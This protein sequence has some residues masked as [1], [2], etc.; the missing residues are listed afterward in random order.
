MSFKQFFVH[1]HHGSKKLS[2]R[3]RRGF[4][5]KVRPLTI[6]ELGHIAQ[7]ERMCAVQLAFCSAADAFSRKEGRSQ[8]EA[9]GSVFINKR[10]L[11]GFIAS[12][13]KK[14]YSRYDQS[15]IHDSDYFYLLKYVV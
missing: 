12:A 15:M 5:C 11:P 6:E 2:E 8:A 9:R 1:R 13:E 10:D 7:G 3:R 4:S 14:M